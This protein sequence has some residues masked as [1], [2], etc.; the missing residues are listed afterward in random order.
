MPTWTIP[1]FVILWAWCVYRII[2]DTVD[3]KDVDDDHSDL[4]HH[5]ED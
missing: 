3:H 4:I 5:N 2:K 1:I